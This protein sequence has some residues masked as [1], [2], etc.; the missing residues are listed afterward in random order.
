M[1]CGTTR[2]WLVEEGLEGLWLLFDVLFVTDAMLCMS[3]RLAGP[4][5]PVVSLDVMASEG[6]GASIEMC[7]EVD[8]SR[9]RRKSV[10]P[11]PSSSARFFR[12]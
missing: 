10:V 8:E 9:S 11:L 1:A 5:L 7:T 2:D 3:L 4:E 12:R 6:D